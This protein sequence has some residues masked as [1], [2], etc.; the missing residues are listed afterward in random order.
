MR[1]KD[2]EGP[3]Q[4]SHSGEA[5][6]GVQWVMLVTSI[7]PD[8]TNAARRVV[9]ID[10]RRA[11]T[12]YADGVDALGLHEGAEWTVA[13]SARAQ[14]RVLYEKARTAAVGWTSKK[15][16]SRARLDARLKRYQLAD[17]DRTALVDELQA[18]GLVNDAAFATEVVET[19]LSREPIAL[20]GLVAALKQRGIE[21]Q[22]ARAAATNAL[23]GRDQAADARELAA[24]RLHSLPPGL[25]EAAVRRRLFAYL[26][27]RG[28]DEDT[29]T[30]A[31]ARI[32]GR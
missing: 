4:E 19:K 9:K 8:R 17:A 26:A 23:R 1:T 29:A 24:K 14:A 11:V 28:F 25:E 30:E 2:Q 12:L 13:L 31:V 32:I 10:R 20:D 27:R 3:D 21:D 18:R 16:M 7:T 6:T 5:D 22:D 15:A